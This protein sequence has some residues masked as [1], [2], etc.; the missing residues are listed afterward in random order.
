MTSD[1]AA[2]GAVSSLRFIVD[3]PAKSLTINAGDVV[4]FWDHIRDVPI[5]GGFVDT[6][7]CAPAFSTG[8]TISVSCVGFDILLDWLVI[9]SFTIP[10]PY[11]LSEGDVLQCLV[12]VCGGVGVPLH[13]R[14]GPTLAGSQGAPTGAGYAIMNLASYSFVQ[15]TTLRAAWT[16]FLAA[17]NEADNTANGTTV[18]V[19]RHF[20]VDMWGGLRYWADQP[21]TALT[22]GYYPADYATLTV[23]DTAAS[24]V[25]SVDLSHQVDGGGVVRNVWVV[26]GNAAGSG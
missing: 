14:S 9:P 6:V 13:A 15:G 17:A 24:A 26:G 21:W 25:R 3:D 20:T 4:R 16:G 7:T 18:P 22:A 23:T 1:E 19:S 12:A 11:I 10:A 2:P 8:R 5:F